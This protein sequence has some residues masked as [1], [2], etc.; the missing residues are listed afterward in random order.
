MAVATMRPAGL[1]SAVLAL[2]GMVAATGMRPAESR[3]VRMWGHEHLLAVDLHVHPF[4]GDGALLP[5]DLAREAHRRALDAIAITAHNQMI[6]IDATGAGPTPFEVLLLPGEEVTMPAVH[7]AAI[8]LTAPVGWRGSVADTAAAI[9]AQGG[10]AIAAHPADADRLAWTDDEYRAVDGLE[11]AHPTMY[12]SPRDR[13]DLASAYAQA[14]RAHPGIAAIGSSDDH[15]AEPIGFCR[16]YVFVEVV[17][18]AGIID[19]IRRGRTVACDGDGVAT[20]PTPLRE[21]AADACRA[22]TVAG[23][24]TPGWPRLATGVAW[25]GLL[26]VAFLSFS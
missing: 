4:P 5:W 12:V 24:H 19:A 18:T 21:A 3:P 8:G 16:T 25:L 23:E 13:A 15:I 2:V 11:V 9:H 26:G 7:I 1:V 17:T 14:G 6:G 20:G 22:D 10:V